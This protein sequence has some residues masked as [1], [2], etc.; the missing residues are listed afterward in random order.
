M[1]AA[2]TSGPAFP[3][4][5]TTLNTLTG[6][7]VVHQTGDIGITKREYYAAEAMKV[8]LANALLECDAGQR[9]D[10]ILE[11][12][13]SSFFIADLMVKEAAK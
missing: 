6:E 9:G 3:I 10:A 7:T 4:E 1:S 12:V 8:L 5:G 13:E 11:S 2:D